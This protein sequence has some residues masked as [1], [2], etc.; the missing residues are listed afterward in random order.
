MEMLKSWKRLLKF[1]MTKLQD[2]K[3]VLGE[4]VE[5]ER[6]FSQY[7]SHL[8][9]LERTWRENGVMT[10]LQ[11]LINLE[12]RERDNAEELLTPNKR[13]LEVAGVQTWFNSE[14]YRDEENKVTNI[15]HEAMK[16]NKIS[17]RDFVTVANFSRFQL[18]L[19]SKNRTGVYSSLTNNDYYQRQP[20][21]MDPTEVYDGSVN[22]A[23][24]TPPKDDPEKLPNS[25]VIKL[26]G[27]GS[28][29][30]NQEAVVVVLTPKVAE[31]LQKY[32]DLKNILFPGMEPEEYFFVNYHGRQ[33]GVMT[34][35]R[36][37]LKSKFK[38]VTGLDVCTVNAVRRG[39]EAKIVANPA[40]AASV[41]DLQNHSA[42]TGQGAYN[43]VA[44]L[45]RAKVLS[46]LA[47][48]EGSSEDNSNISADIQA[49]REILAK[50]DL[51][52]AKKQAQK[53]LE[54]YQ[55][56]RQTS[57]Y[58]QVLHADRKFL[59]KLC[60][61]KDFDEMFEATK[62]P[63]L[64]PKL[65]LFK[66]LFFRIVDTSTSEELV[67]IENR[68]FLTIKKKVEH[69]MGRSWDNSPEMNKMA[70]QKICEAIRNS[71]MSYEKTR[72][73]FQPSFFRFY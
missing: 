5:G 51:E 52:V 22:E 20:L 39:A 58:T 15:W 63:R 44:P 16:K 2:S 32:R 6:K 8:Q 46:N 71:F 47:Q 37:S 13:V 38:Q 33:L 31:Y 45:V 62:P 21:W 10:N 40:A 68:I 66:K 26:P 17:N 29:I 61:S 65:S 18:M 41:K 27:R 60:S 67:E 12:K 30:K 54:R 14:V 55:M 24:T 1:V 4:T 48:Q 69:E 50:K 53:V 57:T 70:D 73:K 11:R 36:G 9:S 28:G 56:N 34:N 23:W 43:K 19:T 64:F 59:Q 72:K 49:K 3:N 42:T 7:S 25:W 35:T